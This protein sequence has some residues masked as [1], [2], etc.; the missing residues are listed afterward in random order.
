MGKFL[1]YYDEHIKRIMEESPI[2]KRQRSER[3]RKVGT[4]SP[5]YL[6]TDPTNY[7]IKDK[8]KQ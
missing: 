4:M 8:E 3:F 7:K 1:E 2:A 5:I 6:H